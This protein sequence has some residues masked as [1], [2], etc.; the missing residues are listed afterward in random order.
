[1]KKKI[2][3]GQYSCKKEEDLFEKIEDVFVFVVN[4][5]RILLKCYCFVQLFK[6]SLLS[7]YT[8][9]RFHFNRLGL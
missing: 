1:M 2:P 7:H 9:V 5:D 6:K 4:G 8:F 3:M